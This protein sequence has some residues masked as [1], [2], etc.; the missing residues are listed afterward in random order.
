MDRGAALRGAT[1]EK[2]EKQVAEE[3]AR[4]RAFC[5]EHDAPETSDTIALYLV[6]T[7]IEGETASGLRRRLQLLDVHQRLLGNSPWLRDKAVRLLLDGIHEVQPR[8]DRTG[9]YDPLHLSTVNV[10]VSVTREATTDNLRATAAQLLKAATGAPTAALA[11]LTW[12]QV[13]L[14]KTSARVTIDTRV[15]RGTVKTTVSTI[16]AA[17]NLS[18]CPVAA[19]RRLRAGTDAHLVLGVRGNSTDVAR[20]TGYLAMEDPMQPAPAQ[21]RDRC[22]LTLG[23]SAALRTGEAAALRQGD[24]EAHDRGLVLTVRGRRHRTY[25]PSGTSTDF[26]PVTA[27]R[28]WMRV[29]DSHGLAEAHLPAFV[30]CSFSKVWNRPVT[31]GGLNF[32]VHQRAAQAGLSGRLAWTSLRSGMIRTALREGLQPYAVAAHVD[33]SSLTSI[34]RHHARER[35]LDAQNVSGLLGL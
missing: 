15:G 34:E 6:S 10:M 18:G 11:R 20:V 23:Y 19:L 26:D 2:R 31:D 13:K 16:G 24:V 27:W 12:N 25:V 28:E 8:G 14:T 3:V 4:L 9:G 30:Q 29:L 22:L 1:T 21:V 7:L 33:L 32:M 35:I 5:R 17:P